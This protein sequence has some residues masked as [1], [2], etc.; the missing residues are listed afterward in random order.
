MHNLN[1]RYSLINYDI[2]I[3]KDYI[4]SLQP[5][6]LLDMC[7]R[8][9]VPEGTL[10]YH[11]TKLPFDSFFTSNLFYPS[12]NNCQQC[13]YK[14]PLPNEKLGNKPRIMELSVNPNKKEKNICKCV[15]G[16]QERLYGNFNFLGNYTIDLGKTKLKSTEVL[17]N[18]KPIILIDLNYIS[19]EL[20]FSP[21]T[22]LLNKKEVKGKF[23]L[24]SVWQQYCR[25]HNL[26]G[27]IMIDLIDKQKI[28]LDYKSVFSCYNY[29]NG[30]ACPEFVLLNE[31]G[32]DLIPAIGTNKLRLIGAIELYNLT[33][34]EVE[35]EYQLLFNRL[36]VILLLY[37]IDIKIKYQE[38]V[39]VFKTLE[40]NTSITN[41]IDILV[42]HVNN[43]NTQNDFFITKNDY[44]KYKD[45]IYESDLIAL[46]NYE[47]Y[48]LELYEPS[49]I[50]LDIS[51][52]INVNHLLP[53]NNT[54]F[55]FKNNK[56]VTHYASDL[57]FDDMLTKLAAKLDIN[58]TLYINY[59]KLYP[60]FN[61][62]NI[63]L[64]FDEL[65]Q[66][67]AADFYLRCFKLYYTT[68]NLQFVNM[69]HQQFLLYFAN[70]HHWKPWFR[71]KTY[72]IFKTSFL[73]IP[74]EKYIC[75]INQFKPFL[76]E[77]IAFDN[78]IIHYLYNMIS[79]T[80]ILPPL[81]DILSITDKNT[82]INLFHFYLKCPDI[83]LLYQQLLNLTNMQ[84]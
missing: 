60:E 13:K 79:D 64:T 70:H 24:Q 80:Y 56:V 30:I 57:L 66:K 62:K 69:I 83:K 49:K 15:T 72:E 23:S 54:D 31:I 29:K 81:D 34:E 58:P 46:Q 27:L 45:V 68:T 2:N 7:P 61:G 3:V 75:H 21:K 65:E 8:I 35:V 33:R 5:I 42:N 76:E 4:N 19:V 44:N 63:K 53:K 59:H 40:A 18:I 43:T 36:Q 22:F 28:Q 52:P 1:P 9:V 11:S 84:Y 67:I 32:D 6:Q 82:N 12:L 17:I 10:F 48:H 50:K 25:H 39:K 38:P 37:N 77:V 73:T 71:N 41:V 26:D 51:S 16:Q 74:T 47:T 14:T 20:G 55:Y 78:F